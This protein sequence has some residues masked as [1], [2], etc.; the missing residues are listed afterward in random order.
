VIGGG[1]W[2]EDRLLPDAARAWRQ[3]RP[4]VL[5]NPGSVRPWQYVLDALL[6]YLLLAEGLC[7]D[8]SLEGA[9]NFG[10]PA[11]GVAV[12]TVA[13]LACAAYGHGSIELAP[14]D[15]DAPHEAR[16][17]ELDAS[18]AREV[19][20]VRPRLSLASAVART[21]HWYRAYANG[22]ESRQLCRA[23]IAAYV[24]SPAGA[25]GV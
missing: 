9:Y 15:G 7:S 21:M 18:L 22:A 24:A 11:G 23:D 16:Q 8:G 6:G 13:E 17:L 20:D 2:A 19:L 25:L 4:L 3:G 10:P 14:D 12:R 5:R 1:D